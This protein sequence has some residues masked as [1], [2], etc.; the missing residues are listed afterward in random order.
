MV[1]FVTCFDCF[2][3]FWFN[4][5]QLCSILFKMVGSIVYCSAL[6]I[7]NHLE[8]LLNYL[9]LLFLTFYVE[10]LPFAFSLLIHFSLFNILKSSSTF[11]TVRL[12]YSSLFIII[13]GALSQSPRHDIGN[14]VKRLSGV[15]SPNFMPSFFETCS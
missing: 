6:I 11:S 12:L 1:T 15:V 13:D 5:V 9:E 8:L 7:L 10:L 4:I 3:Y 2:G 14:R